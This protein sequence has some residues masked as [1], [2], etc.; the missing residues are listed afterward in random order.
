MHDPLP[1][2]PRAQLILT[3]IMHETHWCWEPSVEWTPV[4]FHELHTW[5]QGCNHLGSNPS[6]STGQLRLI[7]TTKTNCT[8]EL[9]ETGSH[10]CTKGPVG[11]LTCE[12]SAFPLPA[13]PVFV[14]RAP[15]AFAGTDLPLDCTVFIYCSQG[16]IQT[17]S[18][19]PSERPF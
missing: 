13:F 5:K 1:P 14:Y 12:L 10:D 2:C 9:G 16:D 8:Q 17:H 6:T 3:L 11:F 19:L 15:G 18:W 4:G 7:F